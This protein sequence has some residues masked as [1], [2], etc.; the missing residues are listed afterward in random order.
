MLNTINKEKTMAQLVESMAVIKISRLVKDGEA[1]TEIFND[2]MV[3]QLEEVL[4][5]LVND[6]K[7][8]IEFIKE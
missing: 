2:E 1:T 7:S 6:P 3:N 4:E 8:M 5:Q